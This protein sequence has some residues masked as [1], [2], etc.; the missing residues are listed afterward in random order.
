MKECTFAPQIDK[1]D[2][3][4]TMNE[5]LEDENKFVQKV[6]D[7]VAKIAEENKVKEESKIANNPQIDENSRALIEQKRGSEPIYEKLYAKRKIKSKPQEEEKK[8]V[9]LNFVKIYFSKF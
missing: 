7:N 3:Q 6:Q 9:N 5:F 8:P 1:T 4:R 2:K